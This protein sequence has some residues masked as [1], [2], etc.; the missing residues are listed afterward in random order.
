MLEIAKYKSKSK[1]SISPNSYDSYK[2]PSL[3]LSKDDLKRLAL[4]FA[5]ILFQEKMETLLFNMNLINFITFQEIS[6]Q[7]NCSKI[8]IL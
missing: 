4:E 5:F 2:I 6:F 3:D 1:N 7:D 8:L